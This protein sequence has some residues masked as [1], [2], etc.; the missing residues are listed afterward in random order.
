MT[1]PSKSS[2]CAQHFLAMLAV[3]S[4]L[5]CR[6][7]VSS[8]SDSSRP[9]PIRASGLLLEGDVRGPDGLGVSGA[10]VNVVAVKSDTVTGHRFGDCLGYRLTP[11]PT[12]TTDAAGHFSSKINVG[13][14]PFDACL[15]LTASRPESPRGDS[16][17]V[18]IKSVQFQ[19]ASAL[20]DPVHVVLHLSR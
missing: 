16:S 6:S 2:Q 13:S 12:E 5:G 14:P 8:S 20:K 1:D 4:A 3:M 11:S 9:P 7:Q 10:R 17:Q 19:P 15:V 18:S